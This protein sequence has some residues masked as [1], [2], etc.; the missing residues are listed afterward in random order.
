MTLKQ[1]QT[2]RWFIIKGDEGKTLAFVESLKPTKSAYSKKLVS[3]LRKYKEKFGGSPHKSSGFLPEY[4]VLHHSYGGW[5]SLWHWLRN[6]ASKVSYHY[7]V[8]T[9]GDRVQYVW[10]SQKAWHAG[11]SA[12]KKK[13]GMNTYSFGLTWT[14]DTN[15]RKPTFEEI[16][17]MAELIAY[18]IKKNGW[19]DRN[20]EDIVLTHQLIA[21][22]RKIDCA[23]TWRDAVIKR[24]KER[25]TL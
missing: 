6:K 5:M 15:K 24:V 20:V 22:N 14:G 9:N 21:P 8:N 2:L 7:A 18:L 1:W 19:T 16:D 25:A 11:K 10:D 17:S 4:I 13:R 12:W 23:R 3:K